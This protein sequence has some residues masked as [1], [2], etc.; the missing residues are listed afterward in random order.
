MKKDRG[1]VQGKG[2]GGVDIQLEW[3]SMYMC[4]QWSGVGVGVV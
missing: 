4:L 1:G 3:L 2:G